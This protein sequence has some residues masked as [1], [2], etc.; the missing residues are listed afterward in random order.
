MYIFSELLRFDMNL[1]EN[2]KNLPECFEFDKEMAA[3]ARNYSGDRKLT[4]AEHIEI[5]EIN[6]VTFRENG[7]ISAG[8]TVIYFDYLNRLFDNNAKIKIL[9]EQK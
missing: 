9:E 3:A 5:F 8:R 1:R 6:P 4:K 7:S 2:V